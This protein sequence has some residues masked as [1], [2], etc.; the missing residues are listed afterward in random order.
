MSA[1]LVMM[2]A[3]GT[4]GH[5]YPALA[6]ASELR[7]R[8]YR[9]GW[10]GTRRGLE[11][12]VVPA[13]GIKL[14]CLPTRG[15]RGKGLL[16]KNSALVLMGI[17]LLQALLLLLK[18][19]P[20]AVVGM[21]GYA[22]VPAALAAWLLRR[23]ILLQEQNAVAGSANR[24]LAPLASTI[25]TGFPGV[26]A[27]RGAR[28]LGNPVR[29]DLLQVA[30]QAPWHWDGS[31]P[32]RVLVL[33]GSL[34]ARP[35]NQAMPAV[36]AELGAR[37]EWLHQCGSAHLQATLDDYAQRAPGAQVEVRAFMENMAE[38]YGWAD[39]VICRAGALT[40]AELAATGRP[41]ILIPLPHAID[42]HQTANARFLADGEAACLLPQPQLERGDLVPLLRDLAGDATRLSAMA[43]AALA[44]ARPRA[45]ADI[46]DCCEAMMR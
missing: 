17:S 33:G 24:G 30:A 40:V 23:P 10:V 13:A 14:H 37:C 1:P 16:Q 35:L 15:L 8:G 39:L 22:S 27:E 21:G 9:L 28:W 43:R 46:T 26:L 38:V 42:D 7:E 4:G 25:V 6:V 2:L 36:A 19:R 44:L 34:G 41:A 12:R 32:L 20:S 3:G 18:D 5:V 29:D 45:T 11:A 31:R